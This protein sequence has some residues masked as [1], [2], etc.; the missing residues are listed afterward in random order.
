VTTSRQGISSPT[1]GSSHPRRRGVPSDRRGSGPT[2]GT[3]RAALDRVL[4]LVGRRRLS[5]TE[6]RVLLRLVDRESAVPELAEALGDQPGEISR[7]GRRLA[8]RGLVRWHHVG[9][10]K[11]TRL[12]ITRAGLAAVRAILAAVGRGR[13]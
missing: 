4:E 10:Q 6:L 3:A 5:A 13:W 8:M 12:G 11:Q 9:G 2:T 7:A 1:A